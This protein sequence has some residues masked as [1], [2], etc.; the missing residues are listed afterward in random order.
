MSPRTCRLFA[1][2][3][4]S[5]KYGDKFGHGSNLTRS[6]ELIFRFTDYSKPSQ[7]EI[8]NIDWLGLLEST[9]LRKELHTNFMLSCTVGSRNVRIIV[10][11]SVR[12]FKRMTKVTCSKLTKTTKRSCLIHLFIRNTHAKYMYDSPMPNMIALLLTVTNLYVM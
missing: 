12:F 8:N 5:W 2:V 7:F 4:T 9:T 10:M 1:I 11:N 6:F 3:V